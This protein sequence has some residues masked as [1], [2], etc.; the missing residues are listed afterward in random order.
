[1]SKVLSDYAEY[2]SDKID[3]SLLTPE[4]YVG[5][6]NLIPN[7]GGVTVSEYVPEEGTVTA[8]IKGDI[9]LGNIRPYFKK[10]WLAEY[11]G[12]CSP[13]VLCI[14]CKEG[15]SPLFLYAVLSQD[16]FFN[17]DVNGSKGTKMPRGDKD[18]IMAFP[19]PELDNSEEVGRLIN[20]IYRAIQNNNAICADFE[21]MAKLLY[22]YW[23]VQF[24]F[25]DKN[26]KPYKSSGGKMVWNEELKREIPVGWK[27]KKLVDIENNIVTGKTPSTKD[28]NNFN[29]AIPFITIGD[30]RGNMY[31]V[32]TEQTL[33]KKGADSQIN[34][35]IPEGSLCV[36]CIASPGLVGFSTQISQTNQQINSIVFSSQYNRPFLYFAVKQSFEITAGAKMGNTFANMNKEDFSNI[37]ILYSENIVKKFYDKVSTLFEEIKTKLIENQQLVSLR[38]FLLPM[39]MNGQVTVKKD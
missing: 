30:I 3:S 39:L 20:D 15:I 25:P 8:F 2:V 6:D 38:D 18:H 19:I 27:L 24:D 14:R 10:I 26:G 1:M 4:T 28:V 29:G 9:L 23:F 5:M 37:Q 31:V 33:S 32:S 35:Y 36:T 11:D 16:I 17:Y 34:K 13:D 22:D 7:K 12:G 21:G